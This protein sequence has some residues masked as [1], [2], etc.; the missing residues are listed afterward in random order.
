MFYSCEV[1]KR[2]FTYKE[3]FKSQKDFKIIKCPKCS[4]EYEL[5]LTSRLITAVIVAL[6]IF[7]TKTLIESIGVYTLVFYAVWYC[8]SLLIMPMF[9]R[10]KKVN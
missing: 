5:V 8:V 7:F 2:K 6:P 10:Y 3:I 9:Y 4:Q 1:C